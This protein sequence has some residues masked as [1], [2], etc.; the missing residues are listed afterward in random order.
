MTAFSHDQGHN[1]N[2]TAISEFAFSHDQGH[3]TN[4]T[5]I[6][7]FVFSQGHTKNL[8]TTRRTQRAMYCC[9]AG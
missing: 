1:T 4:V 9:Q 5:A 2:L 3:D 8:T 6:S 7:D